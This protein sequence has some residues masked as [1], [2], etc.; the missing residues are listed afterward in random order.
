MID[1]RLTITNIIC[2]FITI[3][4]TIFATAIAITKDLP[5]VEGDR[6][7]GI[8]TF[9][10]RLGVRNISFLGTGLLLLN[11]VG[12]IIAA[13]R[14]PAIFNGGI[15]IPAHAL[16]GLALVMQTIRLDAA[17][18]TRESIAAYYRFIWNL[19]YSEYLLLPFL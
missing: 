17:K 14:F 11:Y 7:F 18:Y 10:T 2:S 9:A 12:A 4:V 3:F 8:D 1:N 15:M 19:F 5:D 6:K 16:L 13:A